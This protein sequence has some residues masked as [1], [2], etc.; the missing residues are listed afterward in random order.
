MLNV[1]ILAS[2]TLDKQSLI[3][4]SYEDTGQDKYLNLDFYK[5]NLGFGNWRFQK[6]N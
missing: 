3:K 6:E 5:D 4:H 1:L 2:Q